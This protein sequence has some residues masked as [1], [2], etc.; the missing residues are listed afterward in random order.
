MDKMDKSDDPFMYYIF[1]YK[2]ISRNN[3]DTFLHDVPNLFEWYTTKNPDFKPLSEL[4]KL[5]MPEF[6]TLLLTIAMNVMK[7]LIAKKFPKSRYINK[8]TGISLNNKKKFKYNKSF[9]LLNKQIKLTKTKN[10]KNNSNEII[11]EGRIEFF[12]LKSILDDINNEEI[13]NVT[14][15]DNPNYF[16]Y[17]VITEIYLKFIAYMSG[18]FEIE[19]F[20]L[21]NINNEFVDKIVDFN[22]VDICV[23]SINFIKQIYKYTPFIIFPTFNQLK[24]EI[25][26]KTLSAPVIN[27]LITYTRFESHG[28]YLSACQHIEHDIMFHGRITH[29]NLYKIIDISLNNNNDN[30]DYL[31]STNF[32]KNY[33]NYGQELK[34]IYSN[35][36]YNYFLNLNVNDNIKLYFSFFHESVIGG[37]TIGLQGRKDIKKIFTSRELYATEATESIEAYKNFIEQYSKKY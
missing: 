27:F 22:V 14:D 15:P 19:D 8:N 36:I 32:I 1:D 21:N 34:T 17:K 26:L 12:K 24:K 7:V 33:K 30:I 29:F 28:M 10:N 5:Q 23:Y 9:K 16:S 4:P 37:I 13:L 20:N 35:A 25:V 3:A 11:K 6:A 2:Y 18:N 31:F